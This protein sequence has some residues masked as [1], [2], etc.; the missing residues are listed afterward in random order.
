MAKWVQLQGP[1][2]WH[3]SS[4]YGQQWRGPPLAHPGPF[5][6]GVAQCFMALRW[7]IFHTF[8]GLLLK[9]CMAL[10]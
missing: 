6:W 5:S 4:G 9:P 8:I 7:F 10:L 2:V 3:P 1:S